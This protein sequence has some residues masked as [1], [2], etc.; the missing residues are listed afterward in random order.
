M[1]ILSLSASGGTILKELPQVDLQAL[2]EHRD[3]GY[4]VYQYGVDH[5]LPPMLDGGK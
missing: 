4:E 3:L 2:L 5:G 1:P